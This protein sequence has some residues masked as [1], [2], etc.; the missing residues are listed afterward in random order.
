MSVR[1]SISHCETPALAAHKNETNGKDGF[2]SPMFRIRLL[3][4]PGTVGVFLFL[5]GRWE[6]G[7]VGAIVM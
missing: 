6:A 1:G 7:L 4:D 5:R 3:F 2:P